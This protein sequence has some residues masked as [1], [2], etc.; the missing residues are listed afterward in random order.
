MKDRMLYNR[1]IGG[2]SHLVI[3]REGNTS[4]LAYKPTVKRRESSLK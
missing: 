1:N 2:L 4:G 3:H